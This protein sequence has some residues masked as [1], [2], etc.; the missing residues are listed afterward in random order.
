MLEQ[1]GS[2]F[3]AALCLTSLVVRLLLRWDKAMCVPVAGNLH[4]FCF[5]S[6]FAVNFNLYVPMP[7]FPGALFA[8]KVKTICVFW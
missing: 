4:D 8:S 7:D 6:V 5:R 3:S 2:L 1:T